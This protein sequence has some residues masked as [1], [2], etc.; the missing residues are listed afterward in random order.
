MT[1]TPGDRQKLLVARL[2]LPSPDRTV[3]KQAD[4]HEVVGD[5]RYAVVTE[6]AIEPVVSILIAA[7]QL[8]LS[9]L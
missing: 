2:A 6:E 4:D 1:Y 3:R 5:S 7:R 8:V 9:R